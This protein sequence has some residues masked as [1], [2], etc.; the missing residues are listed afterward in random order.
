M[1]FSKWTS[2]AINIIDAKIKANQI[3]ELKSLFEGCEWEELSK[4][5]RINF[6]KHFANEVRDGRIKNVIA[7]E[8]GRDNHSKYIK[9]GGSK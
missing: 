9:I 6:G 4:G 3:F 2:D 7:V 1:D 8:R 5:D